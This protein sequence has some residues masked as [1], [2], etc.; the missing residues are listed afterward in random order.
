MIKTSMQLKA[1]VRNLSGG[2][3]A[4][5][6][7]IIRAYAMERFLDRL[8]LSRYRGNIIVKGGVPVTSMIG[9]DN[10]STYGIDATV[11]NL[12][13]SEDSIADIVREIAAYRG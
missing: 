4:K 6:Q 12:P 10:R 1:L 8:S 5:A 2:D 7:T 13:L 11:T 3:S 9:L